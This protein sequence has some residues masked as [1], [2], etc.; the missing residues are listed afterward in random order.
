MTFSPVV[1]EVRNYGIWELGHELS[2]IWVSGWDVI[3]VCP[4]PIR[5]QASGTPCV[6]VAA[7]GVSKRRSS[8]SLNRSFSI[9]SPSLSRNRPLTLWCRPAIFPR[10]W[11]TSS[12]WPAGLCC[13]NRLCPLG[14]WLNY[15]S[16]SINVVKVILT[17]QYVFDHLIS[18]FL[19]KSLPVC[20]CVCLFES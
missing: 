9:F 20:V 6:S 8:F 5:G 10:L 11:P 15:L 19:E 16:Q 1:F 14:C 2:W 17:Q 4:L 18:D 7:A 3:S 13:L 12:H